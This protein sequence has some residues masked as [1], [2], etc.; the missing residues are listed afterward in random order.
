[1]VPCGLSVVVGSPWFPF[2]FLFRGP[3]WPFGGGR[4][5]IGCGRAAV[6]EVSLGPGV[7]FWAALLFESA[8]EKRSLRISRLAKFGL[9]KET[10]A[11]QR[12]GFGA[13]K[14]PLA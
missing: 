12:Q 11:F 1:M 5:D 2:S 13:R 7:P 8:V 9:P 14:S 6:V 4:L 10:F 3:L